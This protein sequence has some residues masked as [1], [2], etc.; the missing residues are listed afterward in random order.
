MNA[1]GL[2]WRSNTG[3]TIITVVGTDLRSAEWIRLS[4]V[5]QIR[6]RVKGGVTHKFDGFKEQDGEFLKSFFSSKFSVEITEAV[7]STKGW[8]WGETEFTENHSTL[9]FKVGGDNAFEIPLSEVLQASV[10]AKKG[11]EVSIKLHQ[12][13]T[14][15][16]HESLV[17]MRYHFGA[18]D[19][20]LTKNQANKF[21]ASVLQGADTT[22]ASGKGIVSFEQVPVL[23][24]RGRYD[25]EMF[26]TF[27]E[28]HGK[29]MDYKIKYSSIVRLF[30]LPR[31]DRQNIMLVISLEPPIRQGQ[32]SYQH[33]VMQF[34]E[35][36]EITPT[37]T[38]PKEL[39]N[40]PRMK[41]LEGVS[42]GAQYK[43]I[44]K[45]FKILTDK[46]I[47]IPKSFSGRDGGKGMKVRSPPPTCS[48]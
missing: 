31:P 17:E 37:V 19:T 41:L 4:K 28:M 35:S 47:T 33:V 13:D 15:A 38:I 42:K 48:S 12:D 43:V 1:N 18:D 7:I 30:Q 14:T 3:S 45:V 16:T 25:V 29:S 21:V 6:L 34:E 5:F 2:A 32:T 26:G 20:V 11:N 46:K 22:S 44:A 39:E 8:N 24:P 36:A 10:A 40:D 9:V 23:V 27:L